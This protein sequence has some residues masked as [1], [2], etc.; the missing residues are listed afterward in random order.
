MRP[1]PAL[2]RPLLALAAGSAALLLAGGV[3]PGAPTAGTARAQADDASTLQAKRDNLAKLLRPIT[4]DVTDQRLEDVITFITDFTG[5]QIEARYIDD[6]SPEGLDPESLITIDARNMSTLRLLELV[7]EQAARDS[8]DGATWQFTPWG[9]VEVGL[10]STL[11]RRQRVQIYDISDLL[12]VL[13]DYE[14]AP[15][16]DLQSVLQSS[17][18]GGGGQSPFDDSGGEDDEERDLEERRNN[19]IDLIQSIVEPDQ[20]QA[21]GGDGGSIRIYQNALVVRAADYMHRQID[22]YSFWPSRSQA[23]SGVGAR[24]YVSFTLDTGIGT[25]DGFENVPVLIDGGG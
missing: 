21:N 24:R 15:E 12:L 13:P 22:G 2:R 25:V 23:V 19:V 4:L 20:W 6:R 9:S 11:N 10:K 14:D 1:T 17:Q 7:V 8:F 3:L 5:A 18:G 16:I